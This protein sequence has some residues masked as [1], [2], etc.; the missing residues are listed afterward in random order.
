MVRKA[1]SALYQL[2]G[3]RHVVNFKEAQFSLAESGDEKY[4]PFGNN[5]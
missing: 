2:Q 5:L 4:L 3:Y 1:S